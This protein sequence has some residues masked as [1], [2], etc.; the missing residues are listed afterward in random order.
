MD[1]TA[2]E[3]T[4]DTADKPGDFIRSRGLKIPK[5]PQITRGKM[6]RDLRTGGYEA[7]EARAVERLI[8]R[9]DRVLE[10]GG[11]IGYMSTLVAARRP[12]DWVHTYEANPR[13]IPYMR[14]MHEMNGVTNVTIHNKL[15]GAEPGPP[16]PFYVRENFL[17]SSLDREADE[18]GIVATAMIEVEPLAEVLERLQPNVL[19]C[20][21]EGA[22][23]W[24]LPAGDWSCLR[25]AIIETHPQWIGPK[26]IR[27]VF[28]AMHAGGLTFFPK[29]SEGKVTTFRRDW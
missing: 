20:D 22:E 17:A 26:G 9:G 27:A 28:D 10:L 3:D 16:R 6:R 14:R 23:E 7:K 15:L 25:L 21:I 19:I 4:Q 11:G 29:A 13:L 18:D 12:V 2:P 1:G 5:D 8:R 24:L